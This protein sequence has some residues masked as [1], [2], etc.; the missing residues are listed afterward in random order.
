MRCPECGETGCKQV[1]VPTRDLEGRFV[2]FGDYT[3]PKPE[4]RVDASEAAWDAKQQVKVL[5][6]DKQRLNWAIGKMEEQNRAKDQEIQELRSRLA[7][8]G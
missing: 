2:Q 3:E 8:V 4:C 6:G 5:Y 1:K 7:E